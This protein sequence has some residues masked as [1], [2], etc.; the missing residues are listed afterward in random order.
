M[1]VRLSLV[2]VVVAIVFAGAGC[3]EVPKA[4]PAEGP[5]PFLAGFNL[6][7]VVASFETAPG[8]VTGISTTASGASCTDTW[9]YV[10]RG[11][12]AHITVRVLPGSNAHYWS[13]VR[14]FEPS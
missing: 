12:H 10:S 13:V 5:S 11:L 4:R 8:Q 9:E 7:G 6:P 14:I 2:S 3:E 1:K